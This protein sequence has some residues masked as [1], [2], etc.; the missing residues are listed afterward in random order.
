MWA[1]RSGPGGKPCKHW[2]FEIIYGVQRLHV[3]GFSTI[4]L[5]FST[6]R[7]FLRERAKRWKY[8]MQRYRRGHN[9]AD[10][11][12]VCEQS[13]VGS[14]PTRCAIWGYGDHSPQPFFLLFRRGFPA[15]EHP[16][17]RRCGL[18]LGGEIQVGIDVGGGGEGAVAQPDLYLFHRDAVAQQKAGTCVPL[19][20]N[21]DFWECNLM[22]SNTV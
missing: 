6:R 9:G 21:K 10:S 1:G 17:H 19:W 5:R 4:Y 12:S 16:A 14:N 3:Y 8:S 22:L 18:L 11:K 13:H 7:L 20:H 2:I 15:L